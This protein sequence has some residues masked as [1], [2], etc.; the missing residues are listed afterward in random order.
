M[1]GLISADRKDAGKRAEEIAC[2][3]FYV[4]IRH[5]GFLRKIRKPRK[6]SVPVLGGDSNDGLPNSPESRQRDR[7]AESKWRTTAMEDGAIIVSGTREVYITK[8]ICE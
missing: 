1:N 5:G 3:N 2:G 8:R 7:R 4:S 6:R